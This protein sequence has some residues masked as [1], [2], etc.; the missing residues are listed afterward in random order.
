MALDDVLDYSDSRMSNVKYLEHLLELEAFV[1]G[2]K[3]EGRIL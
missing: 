2:L 1:D 3:Y